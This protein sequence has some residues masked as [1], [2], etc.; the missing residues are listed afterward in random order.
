MTTQAGGKPGEI[1]YADKTVL[2]VDDHPGMRGSI[3]ITLSHFGVVKTDMVPS[4][5]DA[6]R[7]I[8]QRHY[9]IVICD[10]NL[11]EGRD[12]QQLLEELRHGKAIHLATVFLMVT[13]ERSYEKVMSAVELAPDDYLIKP[14]TADT[15]HQRLNQVM[16]RKQVFAPA[17]HLMEEIAFDE[18]ILVCDDIIARHPAYTIDA[19]RLKAELL[20]AEH[21]PDEAQAIYEQVMALRA[22]PWARMGLAKTL[23][24]QNRHEEAES[25]L[26]DLVEQA[27]DYLA[28]YDLLSQVQVAGERHKEAQSTLEKAVA[29]SPNAIL[30]QQAI[31][32]L[33]YDNG[34]LAL[35]EKAFTTV[36]QRGRNSILRSPA[37]H[38]DLVRLQLAQGKLKEAGGTLRDLRESYA[39]HPEA[40][41]SAATMESL[42]H[43][44][45]GDGT[46]SKQALETATRLMREHGIRPD[47]AMSM[48]LAE[49][50][51]ANG[52]LDT[53]HQ[54]AGEL[55]RDNHENDAL[56]NRIRG[57]Y[58]RFG[59]AEAAENVIQESTQAAISLNNQAVRMARGGDLA[60]AI[61][62]LSDAAAR[63]PNN[64]AIQLNAAHALLTLMAGK[65]WEEAHAQA[66]K[67]YLERARQI[68]SRN[69]KYLKV[70]E[71]FQELGKRYGVRIARR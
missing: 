41:L 32:R 23:H 37:D 2:V 20:I 36:V 40:H 70:M 17:Y 52:E 12:G 66:V 55:V 29:R 11:G 63:M 62:L 57:L 21:R 47:R 3:R 34:D 8:R 53:A 46:A 1:D 9:D 28:A 51:L 10:Y 48:S 61:D 67:G 13:A 18:A 19:L 58:A 60:G 30:R 54:L 39:D 24:M 35:A 5:L 27:P 22:V 68:D 49:A 25:L 33:A 14:F 59:H 38:A 7:R 44:H 6:I 71:M 16:R 45:K 4:A 50:C 69:P 31:G 43:S 26:S 56:Q 64:L 15:L 42:L 65:G